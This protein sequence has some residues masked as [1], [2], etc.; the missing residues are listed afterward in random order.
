LYNN[1]LSPTIV[2]IKNIINAMITTANVLHYS[3]TKIY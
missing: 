1:N 3:D 2:K